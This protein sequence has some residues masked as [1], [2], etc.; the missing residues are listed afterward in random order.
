MSIGLPSSSTGAPFSLPST[1]IPTIP[2]AASLASIPLNPLP[3]IGSL[4]SGPGSSSVAGSNT[5]LA[6]SAGLGVSIP[7][8]GFLLSHS[9]RPIPAKLVDRA[10]A[11]QFVEMRDF[12]LDNI[13]LVDRLESVQ[14]A[15]IPLF[16]MWVHRRSA[17]GSGRCPHLFH[18]FI[19]FWRILLLELVTRLPGNVGI[20]KID[21]GRGSTLWR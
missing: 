18:G 2:P 11:G 14:A 4:A 21:F 17:L 8:A 16:L 15:G 9:N 3:G 5:T 13:K 6:S 12:L 10:R 1:V 7:S 20:R 19:V